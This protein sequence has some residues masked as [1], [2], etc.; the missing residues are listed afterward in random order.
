FEFFIPGLDSEFDAASNLMKAM[1]RGKNTLTPRTGEQVKAHEAKEA[2][3]AHVEAKPASFNLTS[4]E[5]AILV[6]CQDEPRTSRELLTAAG[7]SS[8][9]GNFKRSIDRLLTNRLIKMTTPDKPR[10]T[11]QK[12]RLTEK[13]QHVLVSENK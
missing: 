5:I 1:S 11:G 3:E 10:S 12:Y 6:A 2:Q 13:G 8:R 7:Y 4:L 9:T